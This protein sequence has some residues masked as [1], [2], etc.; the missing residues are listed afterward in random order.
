MN[1]PSTTTNPPTRQHAIVIGGSMA[2]LTAARVL[3]NHFAKVTIIERDPPQR[4]DSYRTGVPQGRHPHV[5][6]G[7]GQQLLEE[8]FPGLFKQLLADG[9]VQFNQ[10]R[11]AQFFIKGGWSQPF[12][13]Q[14]VGISCSRPM[15]ESA[16][17]QRMAAHPKLIRRAAV[18][19][20]AGFLSPA[21]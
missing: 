1:T 4:A 17:Y 6:L 18:G 8:M 10:G 7:L 19:P 13:S 20:L 15:L 9:A 3:T 14:I 12:D 16:I 11:E 2:G 21:G 5:L